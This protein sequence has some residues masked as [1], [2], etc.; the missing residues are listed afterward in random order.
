MTS[1]FESYSKIGQIFS[2]NI[3]DLIFIINDKHQCEYINF[4]D[5]ISKRNFNEYIHPDDFKGVNRLIKDIYKTG[6]GILDAQIKYKGNPFKWFEIKGRSFR[7]NEDNE[8]KVLL[9]CRE[10]TKFKDLEFKMQKSQKRFGELADYVPEIQFW[11]LLQTREGKS[12]AQKTR[13]MLELVLDNIPQLIYWKDTN[14]VYMG[15]NKNFALLNQI[16]E[17]TS[18][19]GSTDED[20][21]WIKDN[22]KSIKSKEIEVMKNDSA[23]YN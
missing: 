19:I 22:V 17:P 2:E 5:F 12:V 9:I 18:I 13:E 11:K 10:I 16:T 14:L 15:C 20:L 3:D 8:K 4:E 7:D 1:T 21:I 6:F 23:E